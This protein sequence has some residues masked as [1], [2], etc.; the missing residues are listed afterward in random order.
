MVKAKKSLDIMVAIVLALVVAGLFF[1]NVKKEF[2]LYNTRPPENINIYDRYVDLS[3][4]TLR[5]KVAQML[6]VYGLNDNKKFYQDLNIGGIFLTAMEKP[7]GFIE[8]TGYFQ[9]GTKIPFLFSTDVEGC[10]N[11]LANFAKFPSFS[12]IETAGAARAV[13]ESQGELMKSLGLQVNFA[14]VVDLSDGIWK[15][16][17]F[18]GTPEEISRKAESYIAGLQSKGVIATTKHYPGRTLDVKDPHRLTAAAE[19]TKGDILPFRETINSGVKAVMVSHVI[20]SGEV[21]SDGKPS[22]VSRRAIDAIGKFDGLI[23]TDDI[24]MLGLKRYYNNNDEQMYVDLFAAGND[25]ILDVTAGP[26]EIINIIDTV[27]GAVL[28][29]EVSAGQIDN[30]VRKILKAKGYKII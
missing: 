7:S 27:E 12:E 9:S 22:V 18:P 10:V 20:A 29:G 8:T 15:C 25:M 23:I 24:N 16:R 1:L 13:G 5:Q 21:F 2:D 14:P 30:S 3:T 28:R 4:M 11:T 17:S 26:Q 6:I 19:I